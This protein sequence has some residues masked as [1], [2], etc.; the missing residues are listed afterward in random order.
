MS[1]GRFGVSGLA[2]SLAPPFFGD[3]FFGVSVVRL[4]LEGGVIAL[5]IIGGK[6]FIILL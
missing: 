5:Y 2:P 6:V 1:Q 3:P 4:L